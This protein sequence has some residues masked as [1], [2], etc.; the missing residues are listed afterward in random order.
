MPPTN[1]LSSNLLCIA[2]C[3]SALAAPCGGVYGQK[4]TA[5]P[6]SLAPVTISVL[7]TPFDLR[8]SPFSVSYRNLLDSRTA[9]PGSSFEE[10]ISGITGVQ[11]DKRMNRS[12]GERI[13]IRGMGS[14]AQFG[15]RGVRIV[16]DGI[17]ATLADGQ[18][19]LNNIDLSEVAT[20]QVIRGPASALYGN[21]S[22]GVIL[23]ETH[24]PAY[25]SAAL[26]GRLLRGTHGFQRIQIGTGGSL[27]RN[28]NTLGYSIAASRVDDGG[29]RD[30][31]AAHTGHVNGIVSY[32]TQRGRTQIVLNSE[33]HR[34]QNPGSLSDSL[35]QNN[36]R[37]AFSN[38]IA[39]QTGD[40]G[41]QTQ[42]GVSTQ[43]GLK[44]GSIRLAGH[45]LF[46]GLQNPIPPRII[47]FDRNA[48]GVR[49]EYSVPLYTAWGTITTLAGVETNYQNDDRQN[50][51]NNA[52]VNG[53]IV[54]DQT[55]RVFNTAPFTQVIV[56]S[57]PWSFL[58]GVRY[59]RIAFQA[60]DNFITADNPDDSG[61][62]TLSAFSSS[63]GVSYRPM[64]ALTVYANTAQS[65]Q[66]PTTT[67]L[68]NRSDGAGGFNP[69]L[70]P[71][72]VRSVEI[73]IRGD[74]SNLNPRAGQHLN[75]NLAVYTMRVKDALIP[76]EVPSFA[77]R[78]FFRNAG[79]A[80]YRGLE[81]DAGL[82]VNHVIAVHASYTYNRATFLTDTAEDGG[83]V[84]N[85][86]PGVIPHTASIAANLGRP[87]GWGLNTELQIRSSVF[88]ND[89]NTVSAEGYFTAHLRMQSPE[90]NG[91]ALFAGVNNLFDRKYVGAVV[92]NAFGGRY[93]E[94]AAGRAGYVGVRFGRL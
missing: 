88:A 28:L 80:M 91:A 31:S 40:A 55:E 9:Q 47:E 77:G 29:F 46:R 83:H 57:G 75:Y 17:P 45:V 49:G 37:Q 79:A 33:R 74:L 6:D 22:G 54:L 64:L 68:A 67:E 3:I 16:L 86:I 50:Y 63:W 13:A 2:V 32:Q 43:Q 51:I 73:G 8:R 10:V 30:F 38:N 52:G 18:T 36:R 71:E 53:N 69:T 92:V 25:Q 59:D 20:V 60:N 44:H 85:R 21:A 87:G 81:A 78:Q 12:V 42:L 11:V 48:G 62:R 4:A 15:V 90:W 1:L 56:S 27:S 35:M 23:M 61:R 5:K 26:R 76:F 65:F 39:Q 14:R 84:G 58:A 66:T 82:T 19:V 72:R 34:A 7:R 24:T 70:D 41:H 93:F 89:D 94:P